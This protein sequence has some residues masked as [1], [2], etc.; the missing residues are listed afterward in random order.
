MWYGLQYFFPQIS[1]PIKGFAQKCTQVRKQNP[2]SDF[3]ECYTTFLWCKACGLKLW[4]VYMSV[5]RVEAVTGNLGMIT[6][7]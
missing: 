7:R 4:H 6:S 2:I 5:S 3:Q 1:N